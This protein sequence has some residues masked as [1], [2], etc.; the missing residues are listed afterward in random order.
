M[1]KTVKILIIVCIIL[2]AGI[3]VTTGML[4]EKNSKVSNVQNDPA[5]N[6]SAQN[7]SNGIKHVNTTVQSHT[8]KNQVHNGQKLFKGQ[9]YTIINKE[10]K[11]VGES[12]PICPFCGSK[13][14]GDV[15][16]KT[17]GSYWYY[18]FHCNACGKNFVSYAKS[19]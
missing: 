13:D 7:T 9:Y 17:E 10:L 3:G 18:F 5:E 8:N 6:P 19:S 2:V 12:W 11:Y 1:E 15:G 4:I 16:T 14:T